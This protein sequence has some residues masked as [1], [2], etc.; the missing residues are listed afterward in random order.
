MGN[1]AI[2]RTNL[3]DAVT[4]TISAS[5]QELSLP[6]SNILNA[7]VARRWRSVGSTE[8]LIFDL[9]SVVLIDTVGVFGTTM[10]SSGTIRVRASATDSTVVSSLLYDSGVLSI[11]D[12]YNSH[13]TAMNSPISARFVRL[14]LTDS[15]GDF[16]EVGRV[17]V[18]LRETFQIN[19]NWGWQR[20]WVDRSKKTKTRGGQTQI[21]NDN[22]YR[23]ID[24]TFSFISEN[25]RNDIV[26]EI[27]RING[28]SVDILFICDVESSN[29][30]RDSI[31][32]LIDDVTPVVQPQF[33]IFSKQY[34][35]EE[36]L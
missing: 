20:K 9:G 7:H 16:I 19:F 34:V 15:G 12:A 2:A 28:A 3:V 13:V 6:V 32:G 21:F 25:E 17:F 18:G 22:K 4:T 30:A 23:M 10:S 11:D 31:W 8:N 14:D 5:S 35:V 26:E 24:L 33:D 29:L 36:R 27:D 1:A